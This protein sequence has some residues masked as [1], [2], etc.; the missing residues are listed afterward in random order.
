MR[1][2]SLVISVILLAPAVSAFVRPTPSPQTPKGLNPHEMRRLLRM[3][4]RNRE[5]DRIMAKRGKAR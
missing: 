4:K 5:M 1:L 2:A 3:Q